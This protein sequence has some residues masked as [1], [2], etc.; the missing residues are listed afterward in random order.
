MSHTTETQGRTQTQKFLTQ[1]P[2]SAQARSLKEIIS[3]TTM[4]SS[5]Y[6]PDAAW[7]AWLSKSQ[8]GHHSLSTTLYCCP[9]RQEERRD[10]GSSRRTTM[11]STALSISP[12]CHHSPPPQGHTSQSDRP[13]LFKLSYHIWTGKALYLLLLGIYPD[14]TPP[15]T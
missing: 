8:A 2:I 9:R 4:K 3:C 15:A 13:V 12:D 1:P 6:V 11:P 5:P 10:N 14:H 7:E